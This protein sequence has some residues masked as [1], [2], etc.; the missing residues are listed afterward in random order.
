M[1]PIAKPIAE[2]SIAAPINVL[3]FTF[4]LSDGLIPD[5]A[6]CLL[7]LV[8]NLLMAFDAL[9]QVLYPIL[10]HLSIKI[11]QTLLIV[12]IFYSDL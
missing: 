2:I 1:H 10:L 6:I 12:V 3:L 4:P 5:F 7:M 8:L 11:L 9:L